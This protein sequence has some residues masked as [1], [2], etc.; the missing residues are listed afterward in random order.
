METHH[1]RFREH[2]P[3]RRT[4]SC[5]APADVLGTQKSVRSSKRRRWGALHVCIAWKIY[6]HKQLKR[7]QQKSNSRRVD[8]AAEGPGELRS[9]QKWAQQ[10]PTA[11]GRRADPDP[12]SPHHLKSKNLR[13]RDKR[14]GR[15]AVKDPPVG[16]QPLDRRVMSDLD[17]PGRKEPLQSNSFSESRK[18]PVSSTPLYVPVPH[19]YAAELPLLCPSIRASHVP[20]PTGRFVPFP[21]ARTLPSWESVWGVCRRSGQ[22]RAFEEYPLHPCTLSAAPQGH[23]QEIYPFCGPPPHFPHTMVYG[24]RRRE[25]PNCCTHQPPPPGFLVASY[26]GP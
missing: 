6:H 17:S 15:Q 26:P 14:R 3:R 7:I 19:V 2:L 1:S 10:A 16:D 4:A 25:G 9:E 11:G 24:L 8:V 23:K 21:G 18:F 5:S 20:G 13:W 22:H 12:P